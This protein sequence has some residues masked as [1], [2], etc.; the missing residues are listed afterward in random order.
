MPPVDPNFG[1]KNQDQLPDFEKELEQM[2]KAFQVDG[3]T[4]G[5]NMQDNFM[6]Q[7]FNQN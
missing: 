3:D 1:S 5:M 2:F 4:K 7:M 6:D